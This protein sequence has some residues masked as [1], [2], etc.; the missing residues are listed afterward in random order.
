MDDVFTLI[1]LSFA[2]LVGCYLSGLIP[3]AITFS[4]EKLKLITV[5]GAG[6]LVG[7]ALAVIIP[8]GIHA[9]SES[10]AEATHIHEDVHSDVPNKVDGVHTGEDHAHNHTHSVSD[11]HTIIGVTLVAGFIF[12]LLVDQ[13][14]G[15]H[16]HASTDAEA[17]GAGSTIQQNRHKITATLGLVVHAAADGVAMGAAIMMQRSHLTLIVFIAIML[18]KAPAAFGLVTFLL[19]DGFDKP[20]IRRH[21][22]IFSASAPIACILTYVGLAL[23]QE[24]LGKLHNFQTTGIAMLFSAGTF[25]YVAT[26][27]VLPEVTTSHTKQVNAD[28]T[29][30][31]HEQKGFRPIDLVAIVSGSVI[32]VLLS[33]GHK[34]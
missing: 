34:H 5:F 28:K 16:M 11:N 18:H 3:I 26:V 27:H 29:V 6:L 32:P 20:R 19:H 4:E 33:F 30:V 14:G 23:S 7:T 12:M 10:S 2:M 31:I 13:I 9:M 21:L 22:L 24:S 25:L 17:N 1:I 15:G 8:E